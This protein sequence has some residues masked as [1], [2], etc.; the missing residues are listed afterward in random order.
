MKNCLDI[1]SDISSQQVSFP[2]LRVYY[3]SNIS[4]RKAFVLANI[5]G[6]SITKNLG[7]YLCVPLI[8]GR[9]KKDTY[10]EILLKTQKRLST[11]NT[12][13][14]SFADRYTLIKSITF[15]IPV[16]AMQ[17]IKL[18]SKI[19]TS[20]DKINRD[21]LWGNSVDRKKV[22]LVKWDTVCLPKNLRA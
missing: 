1:F 21:F 2:K 5:C 7:S 6:S 11:W 8:H 15:A 16:Y 9:I 3:T 22:H 19:S 12:V 10:R 14:L 18:P 4:D 20:H 17:S 13:S